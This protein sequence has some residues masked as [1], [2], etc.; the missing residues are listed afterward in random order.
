[1]IIG[2]AYFIAFSL[3]ILHTDVFNKANRHKMQKADYL[4]N[5]QGEGIGNEILEVCVSL[6]LPALSAN[7][8][9]LL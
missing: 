9:V 4:K 1:M 6:V 8:L 7:G 5:T 3:L 2:S